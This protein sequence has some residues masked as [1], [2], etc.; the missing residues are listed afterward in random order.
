[1]KLAVN[2]RLV[3]KKLYRECWKPV[4]TD[5]EDYTGLYE[6]SNLGRVRIVK[7]GKMRKLQKDKDG[8][9]NVQLCKNGKY[10]IY[11]VH[12]LVAFAFVEGWFEGAC[13]DH[14]IPIRNNGTNIWTNLRW[15]THKENN[16]NPLS[17]KNNSEAQKGKTLSEEHKKKLGKKVICIETGQVFDTMVEASEF[18]GL[19]MYSISNCCLGKNNSAGGFHWAYYGCSEE[20][21]KERLDKGI[22]NT[23]KK[24][25]CIE[26]SQIF[27]STVEAGKYVS[28][29]PRNISACCRGEQRS[30]RGFHWKY[31]EDYLKEVNE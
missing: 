7:T 26:T 9:L 25:I 16:N 27:N 30:C 6:I 1:M 11:K 12:R 13:V 2:K 4:I 17:S 15:V 29:N 14:I 18:I 21:M 8:Y 28:V 5:E 3:G 22:G 24:V 10:R 23:G 19:S 20:E 31:Y